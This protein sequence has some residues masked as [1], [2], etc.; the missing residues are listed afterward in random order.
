MEKEQPEIRHSNPRRGQFSATTIALLA[1]EIRWMRYRREIQS[2]PPIPPRLLSLDKRK[3]P[4]AIASVS[5]PFGWLNLKVPPDQWPLYLRKVYEEDLNHLFFPAQEE[6]SEL[7]PVVPCESVGYC[8]RKQDQLEDR[9][10][11]FYC[12]GICALAT[13]GHRASQDDSGLP[14]WA[15][16][17][18][19]GLS[20]Q[21]VNE[22][23][24]E[25]QAYLEAKIAESPVFRELLGHVP[26]FLSSESSQ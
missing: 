13:L 17:R 16:G 22:I 21:R 18:Y 4:D 3:L 12:C 1:E 24:A 25:A 20:R 14:Y 5:I 2:L 9:T 6:S 8:P 26:S 10:C 19:V 11:P 15:I 23:G 7:P